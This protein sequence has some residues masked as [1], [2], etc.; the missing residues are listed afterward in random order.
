MIEKDNRENENS[1]ESSNKS[2]KAMV[3]L[4]IAYISFNKLGY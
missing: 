4:H 2:K 3:R 1:V